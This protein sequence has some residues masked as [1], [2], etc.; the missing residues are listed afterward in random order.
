MK[1]DYLF[2]LCN[3]YRVYLLNE[4]KLIKFWPILVMQLR[5]NRWFFFVPT[6]CSTWQWSAAPGRHI[7]NDCTLQLPYNQLGG[8]PGGE[9]LW[10]WSL[11]RRKLKY[12]R[13]IAV[14][15]FE[16]CLFPENCKQ[17]IFNLVAWRKARCKERLAHCWRQKKTTTLD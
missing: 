8:L 15:G 14:A 10:T 3:R 16:G 11:W 17:V 4:E 12:Q 2:L 9:G 5:K 6:W 13:M 7:D 1:F